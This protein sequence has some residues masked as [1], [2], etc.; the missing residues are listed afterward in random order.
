MKFFTDWNA[1]FEYFNF[2]ADIG[3]FVER[4]FSQVFEEYAP[5]HFL[6]FEGK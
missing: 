3:F 1:A 4:D 5:G 6:I 2:L